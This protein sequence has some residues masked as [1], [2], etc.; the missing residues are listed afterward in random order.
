VGAFAELGAM[1]NFT[2][3]EGASHPREV[4][5]A[6]KALGMEAVGI[7]DRNS[8][9]GLVR[10]MVAAEQAGIRF[11]PGIRLCLSDGAEYLAWPTDR[12]AWGRLC[13]MLSA[14]RMAGDKGEN[15]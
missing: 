13:R 1:T 14:A 10:G 15:H 7:A 8:V 3:L 5:V 4:V 12:A 11:V 2:F 6:A 9:A